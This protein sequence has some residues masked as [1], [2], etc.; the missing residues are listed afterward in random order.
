[1]DRKNTFGIRSGI[2]IPYEMAK[3][4]NPARQ[5]VHLLIPPSW[6]V[7][8]VVV[9]N[10]LGE[11]ALAVPVDERAIDVSA[12]PAGLYFIRVKTEGREFVEKVV[13]H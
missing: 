3:I 6:K 4:N 10:Q 13:V 8:A 1:M 9:Y 11:P 2:P 5:S 7:Q 12:L